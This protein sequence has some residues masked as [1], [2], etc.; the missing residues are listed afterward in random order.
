MYFDVAIY[1]L[2]EQEFAKDVNAFNKWIS[3]K[4]R[5]PEQYEKTFRGIRA[6]N[7]EEIVKTRIVSDDML[8]S[9]LDDHGRRKIGISYMLD[10]EWSGMFRGLCEIDVFTKAITHWQPLPEMP[11]EEENNG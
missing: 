2:K 9:Y 6:R 1:L 5:L 3:V 4:D 11:E 7:G 10:G 8:V